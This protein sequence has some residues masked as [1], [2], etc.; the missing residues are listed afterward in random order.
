MSSLDDLVAVTRQ[1]QEIFTNHDDA[2]RLQGVLELLVDADKARAA[3]LDKQRDVL[4]GALDTLPRWTPSHPL[5][6][7]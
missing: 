6:Q 3:E 1:T 2:D 4:R 7:P 5:A